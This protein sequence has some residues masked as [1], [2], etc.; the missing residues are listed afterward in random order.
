MQEV[1]TAIILLSIITGILSVVVI[2]LIG[3]IIA[4]LFRLRQLIA[5]IDNIASNISDATEWLSPIKVV[6]SIKKLFNK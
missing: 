3:I 2:V 6:K 1:Q 5:R 4:I